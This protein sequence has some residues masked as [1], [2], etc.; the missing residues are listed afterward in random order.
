VPGEGSPTAKLAIVG[1]GP[2]AQEDRKGRP[3]VGDAGHMLDRMLGNV[4]ELSREEVHILNV[5]KCRPP[6]NRD[7]KPREIEACLPYLEEQIDALAPRLILA[8]GAVSAKTLTGSKDG[9]MKTRGKL[10]AYR[11]VTVLPTYHPAFLLRSPERKREAHEDLLLA[12][13]I[14]KGEVEP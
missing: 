10:F 2:G 9:I 8:L 6:G 1:E 12:K 11:G 5:V 14:L 3:F 13:S 7:P 4:L